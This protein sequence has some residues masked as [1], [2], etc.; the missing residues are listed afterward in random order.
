MKRFDFPL[1]RVRRWRVE[2][3]HLE[4]LKLQQLL[5]ERQALARGKQQ[6]RQEL[7]RTQR[8]LLAQP[9]LEAVELETLDC[10]HHF[11]HARIRDFEN[12]EGEA[13]AKIVVQRQ[14]VLEARRQSE[15]LER[16]RHKALAEWRAA[17]DHE[18]ETLAAEL[19]L[20]KTIRNA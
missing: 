18:Q 6:I 5:A 4:E 16:L 7:E 11:V 14:R 8:S 13:E 20:A 9:S 2:Q 17:A 12:R 10:F 1:D 19:F 3:L 15:L